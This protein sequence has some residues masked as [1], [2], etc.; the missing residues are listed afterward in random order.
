MDFNGLDPTLLTPFTI[1]LEARDAS[2]NVLEIIERRVRLG[3]GIYSY[4]CR[5]KAVA[6]RD[7]MVLEVFCYN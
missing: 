3:I 2:N 5:P 4:S 6:T 7:V 1:I